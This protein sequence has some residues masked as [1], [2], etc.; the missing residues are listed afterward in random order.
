MAAYFQ[1]V[2]C[3]VFTQDR[4][5]RGQYAKR[6][7]C[8][9]QAMISMRVAGR[10]DDPPIFSRFQFCGI[11][12]I[13]VFL[14]CRLYG[15]RGRKHHC[16]LRIELLATKKPVYY[17]WG[18]G[19][20]VR[21]RRICVCSKKIVRGVVMGIYFYICLLQRLSREGGQ[22]RHMLPLYTCYNMHKSNKN[23]TLTQPSGRI[24]SILS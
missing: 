20:L 18:L 17:V 19:G 15:G 11:S 24:Q 10:L 5:G 14:L 16:L 2:P 8:A 13:G 23:T 12:K 3:A 1:Y 21:Y 9:S 6:W 7:I 22:N 4:R